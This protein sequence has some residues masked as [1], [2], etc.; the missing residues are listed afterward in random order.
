MGHHA[1]V[2]ELLQPPGGVEV[3]TPPNLGHAVD[4]LVPGRTDPRQEA[5]RLAEGYLPRTRPIYRTAQLRALHAMQHLAFLG[6]AEHGQQIERA[7]ER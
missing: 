4:V 6:P 3:Q 7:H 5:H 1:R 2:G